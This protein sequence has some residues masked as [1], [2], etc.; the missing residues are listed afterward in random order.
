M[1]EEIGVNRRIY[2]CSMIQDHIQDW[3]EAPF[4]VG[5]LIDG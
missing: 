3:H 2:I 5:G 1:Y 4:F